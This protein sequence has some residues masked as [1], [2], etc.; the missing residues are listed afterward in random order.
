[1]V[2]TSGQVWKSDKVSNSWE[3]MTLSESPHP[4]QL[5]VYFNE[6]RGVM[7]WRKEDVE[8]WIQQYE[9]YLDDKSTGFQRLYDKLSN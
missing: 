3:Q 1:M 5:G 6:S 9:Y 4:M 7:N 2:V 8:H